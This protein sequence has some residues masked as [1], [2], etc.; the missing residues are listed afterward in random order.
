MNSYVGNG[1]K[2]QAAQAV[3]EYIRAGD[4][5]GVGSGSTVAHF[6]SELARIKTRIDGAVASSATTEQQLRQQRIPI[7][8]LNDTGTLPIYVDGTDEADRHLRL[9]KGGGGALTREKIIAQASN[10]FVC[11][12]DETKLVEQLGRHPLPVEVIPMARSLVARQLASL[13]GTPQLRMCQN[14][15][16]AFTTDNGNAILDVYGLD[17]TDPASLEKQI[18]QFPGVVTV[19]LFALRRADM[20]LLGYDGE[21][22]TLRVP[23]SGGN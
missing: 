18:S 3:I 11:I 4:I 17:M 19:G 22:K 21:V 9:I 5:V 15:H 7:Y 12:A 13:G 16:T 14:A 10:L 8:H 6:V 23:T 20:L 2:R 1:K